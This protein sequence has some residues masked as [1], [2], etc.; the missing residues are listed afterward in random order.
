MNFI[1]NVPPVIKQQRKSEKNNIDTTDQ[2]KY[3]VIFLHTLK[4]WTFSKEYPYSIGIVILL[5]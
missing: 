1:M 5:I 4:L 2:L 3:F